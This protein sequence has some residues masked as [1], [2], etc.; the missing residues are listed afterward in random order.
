V[1]DSRFR[2]W[3]FVGGLAA[4]VTNAV[5]VSAVV[6]YLSSGAHQQF[7]KRGRVAAA[8]LAFSS[9]YAVLA[10][11][12]ALARML[13]DMVV[14]TDPDVAFALIRTAEG[15]VLASR[16]KGRSGQPI[17]ELPPVSEAPGMFATQSSELGPVL[18]FR[19]PVTAPDGG[20][21]GSPL[22]SGTPWRWKATVDLGYRAGDLDRRLPL[23]LGAG[24]IGGAAAVVLTALG[25]LVGRS[26]G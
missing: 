18:C 20:T 15:T 23:A 24:F 3:L 5:V 19:Q 22:P 6:F 2:V 11:D 21:D 10:H 7:E 16:A 9:K 14:E 17:S 8:N 1:T 12:Q 13:V 26:A 4:L 25:A